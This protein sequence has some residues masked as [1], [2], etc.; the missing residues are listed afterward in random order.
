MV[1]MMTEEARAKFERWA[2]KHYAELHHLG[3]HK[4]KAEPFCPRCS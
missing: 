4:D 3:K 2:L 1:K